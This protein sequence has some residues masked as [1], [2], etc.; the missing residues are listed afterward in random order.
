MK[1]LLL[2]FNPAAGSG[3]LKNCMMDIVCKFTY[4]GYEVTAHPTCAPGDARETV[5]DRG[6]QYDMVVC[7][8]GDGTLNEVANGLLECR[9]MPLMGYIPCGTTNDFASSLRLPK[10]DALAAAERIVSPRKQVALD[11]GRFNGKAFVYVAAFGA[12]T[13]VPYSTPQ[14]RK[15]LFGQFAYVIEGIGK[16]KDVKSYPMKVQYDGGEFEGDYAL[17]M[18]TNS[19]SVGGYALPGE[20]KTLLDD[21]FF[22]VF[23]VSRPQ[24]IVEATELSGSLIGKNLNN[25][26]IRFLR[27]KEIA[28]TAKEDI[29]WTLDGEYGGAE[30]EINIEVHKNQLKM[31]V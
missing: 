24:N 6:A 2:V 30:R 26:L 22:E 25:P 27:V 18:V 31:C 5:L 3:Q 12:F 7:C 14:R 21:G 23:L 15:N 13:E 9:P 17:G 19:T 29:P 4:A 10:T 8:G 11:I 28:F 16:L 20:A 1:R